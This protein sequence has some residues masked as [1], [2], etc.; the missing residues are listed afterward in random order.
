M[1]SEKK[2]QNSRYDDM[3]YISIYFLRAGTSDVA[4][5]ISRANAK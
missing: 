5:A 4:S 1:L 2:T 3:D